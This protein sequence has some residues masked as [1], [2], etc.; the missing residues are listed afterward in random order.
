M[1]N[2]R[3]Y[4]DRLRYVIIYSTKQSIA[5]YEYEH[6]QFYKK[7]VSDIILPVILLW[8]ELDYNILILKY[9]IVYKDLIIRCYIFTSNTSTVKYLFSE[10][11]DI[12][13]ID[14]EFAR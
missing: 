10:R 2:W 13:I 14:V 4:C 9:T 11:Y 6:Y 7:I 5:S 8:P 1:V 12:Y 3:S